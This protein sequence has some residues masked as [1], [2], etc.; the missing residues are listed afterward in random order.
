MHGVYTFGE[1]GVSGVGGWDFGEFYGFVGGDGTFVPY[2]PPSRLTILLLHHLF[3]PI[4]IQYMQL[5]YLYRII[6]LP[7]QKRLR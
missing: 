1:G 2:L 4:Y 7:N 3:L 6:N 5:L